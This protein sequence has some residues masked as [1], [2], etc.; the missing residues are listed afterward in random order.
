[1][2]GAEYFYYRQLLCSGDLDHLQHL[3]PASRSMVSRLMR[4]DFVGSLL[5][6]KKKQD[7]YYLLPLSVVLLDVG[8]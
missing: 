3:L 1:M 2:C 6:N 5:Q 4:N 8:T 7:E